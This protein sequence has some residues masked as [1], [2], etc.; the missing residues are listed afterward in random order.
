VEAGAIETIAF[1]PDRLRIPVFRPVRQ[2]EPSR[3]AGKGKIPASGRV[4]PGAG[5]A[6]ESAKLAPVARGEFGV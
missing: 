3:F 5:A 1:R 2:V 6:R 4:S